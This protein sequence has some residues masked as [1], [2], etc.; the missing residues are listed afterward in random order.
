MVEEI[1]RRDEE[2]RTGLEQ[3]GTAAIGIEKRTL[4][5]TAAAEELAVSGQELAHNTEK[6][7]Q[8]VDRLSVL[9]GGRGGTRQSTSDRS[10]LAD[11]PIPETVE[12]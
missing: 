1:L 2:Q 8:L 9:L 5:T 12:S 10:V 11:Q 4:Q 6:L 7:E 3:I